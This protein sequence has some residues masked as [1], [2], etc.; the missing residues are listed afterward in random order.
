MGRPGKA[1]DQDQ[2]KEKTLEEREA[3]IA[4][5]EDEL[6]KNMNALRD[7]KRSMEHEA[8]SVGSESAFALSEI[9]QGK[10]VEVVAESDFVKK[11]EQDVFFNEPVKIHVHQDP[12]QGAYDVI[13]VTVGGINQPII[14]GKDQVV[15][16]KYVAALA[17]SR[18]TG[19]EQRTPNPS[20]PENIQLVP[21]AVLSYPFSVMEDRNPRGRAWLDALLSQPM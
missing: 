8:G 2:A 4:R 10:G 16:R 15:K 6:I 19:Y 17:R 9:G 3:D 13:T 11:L 14:R 5:R 7:M 21:K 18:I 1:P 20:Q 12:T